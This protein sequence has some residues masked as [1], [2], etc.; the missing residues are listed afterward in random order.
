VYGFVSIA[1]NNCYLEWK[2]PT[3]AILYFKAYASPRKFLSY[4]Y[5]I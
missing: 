2:S 5:Y 1:I 4:F 3:L